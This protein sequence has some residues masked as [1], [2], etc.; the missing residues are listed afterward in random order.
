MKI[1]TT[2]QELSDICGRFA[3]ED[4]VTVDTEFMR[5]R[6]YWP[7]LCL[8][9]M[10]SQ[11]HEAMVDPLAKDIALDPFF[12]LMGD[13]GT[14][15]VF[16]SARQDIEI[17]CHMGDVIPK[18]LF[19]TQVAAMVCGFGDSVGYENLVRKLVGAR[20]DKTSRFTDWSHR[21][22]SEKQLK[23]ALSDV[24][25]LRGAYAKLKKQLDKNGREAWLA[26]E[27]AI[28][29]SPSTYRTEP[30]NAWKRLKYRARTKRNLA[31]FIEAAAWREREA[32][33]RDVPR[34]RILKDEALAEIATQIPSEPGDFRRLRA[35]PRGFGESQQAFALLK[36]V[37][38]ALD[39]PMDHVPEVKYDAAAALPK[40]GAIVEVLKVA[41][42]IASE[43]HRVAQKLIASVGDLEQ[44]AHDD[45]ADV[46]AL[47]G[48][49]REL[50]GEAALAL[51]HGRMCIVIEDGEAL[52]V[53]RD[54]A[55]TELPMAVSAE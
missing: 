20:I 38:Q 50:F 32:Q 9:Q 16:H 18:P 13:T 23:Y 6:T 49:R 36:G 52:F 55:E 34:N 3:E 40:P 24:T 22:L 2:T 44:I 53:P 5:E 42:R 46:R 12:R 45:E 28:L 27:M 11:S 37:K 15:K 43:R 10:A 4:F 8:I 30:E 47:K 17:M 19:D 39:G 31:V 54:G 1:I 41:L 51:K 14:V 29:E 35:V 7:K 33:K 48:W 26:E 21:P 25:H